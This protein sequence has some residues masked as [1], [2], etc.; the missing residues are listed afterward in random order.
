MARNDWGW[1]QHYPLVPGHEIIGRIAKVGDKADK[2]KVGDLV[3]V[4]CM[5]DSCREC[6]PCQHGLE[7]YC[8]VGNIGTYGGIDRFDG[9]PTQGGY[10]TGVVVSEDFVLKVSEKLDTKAVAPL[11]CAGITTY[12]PLRHWNVKAGSKVAVVG[13][14]GLGHMAVKLAKAMGAEVTLFTR[15]MGKAN[16]AYRLGQA[17]WCFLSMKTR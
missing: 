1:T 4:G 3:G 15:S 2:F 14:G 16:D 8:E 6:S 13:L 10:S 12:S 11:L 17:V 5:V 9:T 7:Q